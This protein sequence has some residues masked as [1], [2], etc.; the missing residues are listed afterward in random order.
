MNGSSLRDE[1]VRLEAQIEEL[2][3][4]IEN[5]RKFI[6]AG[7]IAAV[8]GG[9]VLLAMLLGILRS[10]PSM[11]GLA[12]AAALGGIVVAGS[13]RST[14]KEAS[15]ELTAAEAKRAALIS[16]LTLRTVAERDGLQS[17]G[18]GDFRR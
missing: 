2:A 4:R 3:G 9:A 15:N 1:I 8:T 13:N 10:E 17:G 6:L 12:A 14:A 5:C 11:M 16:Q 7:R 18:R